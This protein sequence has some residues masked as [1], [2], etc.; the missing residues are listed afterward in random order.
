MGAI[1]TGFT[2]AL[3]LMGPVAAVVGVFYFFKKQL[4]RGFNPKVCSAVGVLVALIYVPALI[5][6]S[7]SFIAMFKVSGY[8]R[9]ALMTQFF[10][11]YWFVFIAQIACLLLSQILWVPAVRRSPACLGILGL[12]LTFAW[13]WPV[14]FG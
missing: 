11:P 8:Q 13:S 2:L 12:V 4:G 14:L 1:E 9:D 5:R 6:L 3:C 10:G 7:A